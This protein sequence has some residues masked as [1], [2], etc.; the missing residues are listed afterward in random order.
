MYGSGGCS[1]GANARVDQDVSTRPD[2]VAQS[3]AL[4][5]TTY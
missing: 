1:G 2:V 4:D 5:T 3:W